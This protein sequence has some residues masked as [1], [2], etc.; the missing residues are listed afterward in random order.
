MR[1]LP[2]HTRAGGSAEV[3]TFEAEFMA[4]ARFI[5]LLE[6]RG[7][8]GGVIALCLAGLLGAPGLFMFRVFNPWNGARDWSL[9]FSGIAV[10]LMGFALISG[11]AGLR[12]LISPV[13]VAP[14]MEREAFLRLLKRHARP[15]RVCLRCRIVLDTSMGPECPECLSAGDCF[16]VTTDADVRVVAAALV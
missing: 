2:T 5:Q 8:W 10:M 9:A 14:P 12:Y 3:P 13:R 11:T 15:V 7:R 6:R 16:N 1:R 4:L